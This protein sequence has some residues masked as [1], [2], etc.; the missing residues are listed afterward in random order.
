MQRST[1]Q[2]DQSTSHCRTITEFDR[3]TSPCNLPNED[4]PSPFAE[5][6]TA[7][8]GAW[9][10]LGAPQSLPHDLVLPS[11][12]YHNIRDRNDYHNER[13]E[14]QEYSKHH[15][16]STHYS[17]STTEQIVERNQPFEPRERLE[18]FE[19]S[20]YHRR[21]THQAMYERSPTPRPRNR[22]ST[23]RPYVG[24]QQLS[25]RRQRPVR[26]HRN[27]QITETRDG[28]VKAKDHRKTI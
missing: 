14:R 24:G 26:E 23:L 4:L 15:G 8:T 7:F 16:T 12:Q 28:F 10:E 27:E 18:R 1:Y 11:A 3:S 19:Q 9:A 17:H 22:Q 25:E 20:K 13:F 21:A 2:Y 5:D 6:F